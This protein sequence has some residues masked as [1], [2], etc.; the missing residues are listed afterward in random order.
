MQHLSI[1]IDLS[2]IPGRLQKASQRLIRLIGH[3]L[4]S[5]VLATESVDGIPGEFFK[6]ELDPS[7]K[8]SLDETRAHFSSWLL[9]NAFR[10][11][12][13]ESHHML[14]EAHKVLQVW[15]LQDLM[16]PDG[17]LLSDHAIEHMVKLPEKFHR[18]ALPDKLSKLLEEFSVSLDLNIVGAILSLNAAR[19][20]IVHREGIVGEKDASVT[21]K[22]DIRWTKPTLT[23]TGEGGTRPVEPGGRVEAGEMVGFSNEKA[24]KSFDLGERIEFSSAEFSE[25]CWTF[26]QFGTEI[27][28]SLSTIGKAEGKLSDPSGN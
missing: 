2:G 24:S 16:E 4:D 7:T 25:I 15:R 11:V 10:E 22:L 13:E 1:K 21:G 26:F 3:G 18:L 23:I 27:Q 28:R 19:N 9:A 17:K 8:W 12:T 6:L 20:C 5:S 14:D